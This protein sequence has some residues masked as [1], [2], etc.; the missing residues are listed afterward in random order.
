MR[1]EPRSFVRR[2][3]ERR[4]ALLLPLHEQ[5][6]EVRRDG[7]HLVRGGIEAFF[8]RGFVQAEQD[9]VRQHAQIAARRGVS[10]RVEAVIREALERTAL[11]I[12]V[13][14]ADVIVGDER[15]AVCGKEM[16]ERLAQEILAEDGRIVTKMQRA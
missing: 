6:R 7:Q 1:L 4:D 5:V 11:E 16:R 9:V 12:F 2:E 14:R 15:V 8:E 13:K 3:E 10:L